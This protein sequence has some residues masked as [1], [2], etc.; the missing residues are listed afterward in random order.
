MKMLKVLKW[1]VVVVACL[2]VA[3]QFRRPAR[4]NP[5]VDQSQTIEAHAQMT[6]QV[7]SIL[8]RSCSD[9]HSHKTAWPW[10]TNVAPISWFIVN[11][12]NEGRH[13]MNLSEWGRYD[14][15]RQR[16]KLQQMCEEVQDGA[17]P[18]S[19]Y[20]PL[21]PNSKLSPDDVKTLCGWTEAERERLAAR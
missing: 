8:A 17:M 6:P 14:L 12:V 9:C 11:H 13:N 20:T 19:T 5:P 7:A 15:R 18:L 10:Y 1:L 4:T 2:F 21:H 3:A 16:N